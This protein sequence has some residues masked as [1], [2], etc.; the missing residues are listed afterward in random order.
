MT[1]LIFSYL[2]VRKTDFIAEH[3]IK[4]LEYKIGLFFDNFNQLFF[5]DNI[6]FGL[7]LILVI[8][9]LLIKLYLKQKKIIQGTDTILVL[10]LSL[11]VFVF[12]ISNFYF[13]VVW[14]HFIFGLWIFYLIMVTFTLYNIHKYYPLFTNLIVTILFLIM[15]LPMINN[16]NKQQGAVGDYIHYRNHIKIVD[17]IY[18]DSENEQ[19]N[20]VVYEPTT[21]SYTYDYLFSWYGQ[22]TYSKISISNLNHLKLVYY[23]IEPDSIAGRKEKW[24]KE[25]DGDGEIIWEKE[26]WNTSGVK[27][28]GL[29]L[30]KRIR[31]D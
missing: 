3:S 29:L 20:V 21:F 17:E 10:C 22:K 2:G 28:N 24:I 9:I 27:G 25:R 30:Q 4:S 5:R 13:D 23:I 18:N 26:Y 16:L 14:T 19:F 6:D 11:I 15:L 1:K 31:S 12:I 7:I 8:F